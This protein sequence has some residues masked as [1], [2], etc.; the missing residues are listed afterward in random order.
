MSIDSRQV[1]GTL[2]RKA[3]HRI[4]TIA[5]RL[6][7]NKSR[8]VGRADQR[9]G[10][11]GRAK[12]PFYFR[13]DRRLTHLQLQRVDQKGMPLVAAVNTNVVA[14]QTRGNTN[15]DSLLSCTR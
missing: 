13:P 14:S 15:T 7:G 6:G 2:G 4:W 11:S 9:Q 5:I 8:R 10:L 12:T 1:G 3:L